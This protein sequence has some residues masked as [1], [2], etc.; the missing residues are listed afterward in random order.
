M[1]AGSA[2]ATWRPGRDAG[3]VWALHLTGIVSARVAKVLMPK[4]ATPHPSCLVSEA[5]R[6]LEPGEELFFQ[7]HT[8]NSLGTRLVQ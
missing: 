7:N 6:A 4:E 2:D 1:P 8:A 5:V 3:A